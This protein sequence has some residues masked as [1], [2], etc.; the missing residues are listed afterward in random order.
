MQIIVVYSNFL[1]KLNSHSDSFNY[2][3]SAS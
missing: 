1:K 2:I 3:V